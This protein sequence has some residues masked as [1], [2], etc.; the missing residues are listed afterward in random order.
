MGM[1]AGEG[2]KGKR[3]GG[4]LKV[5]IGALE[6]NFINNNQFLSTINA[7]GFIPGWSLM[8]CLEDLRITCNSG[9]HWVLHQAREWEITQGKEKIFELSGNQTHLWI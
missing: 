1:P 8:L 4:M 7:L 9:S 3:G 5:L 2:G 6:W